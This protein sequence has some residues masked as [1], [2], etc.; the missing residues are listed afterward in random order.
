VWTAIDEGPQAVY[1]AGYS[2][3]ESAIY[4]LTLSTAGSFPVLLA[5][6]TAIQMAEGEKVLG[7]QSA[8]GTVI[9]VATSRGF[10]LGIFGAS[11]SIGLGPLIIVGTTYGALTTRDR[12]IYVGYQDSAGVAGMARVDCGMPLSHQ[13][14]TYSPEQI[15]AWCPDVRAE[16]ATL[17]GAYLGGAV[18]SACVLNDRIA[19]AVTGQGTFV[20]HPS[21]LCK[22]GTLLSSR[23]RMNTLELKLPRFIRLRSEVSF[24]TIAAQ[25]GIETDVAGPTLATLQPAMRQDS[26]DVLLTSPPA[27]WVTLTFTLTRQSDA[28]KDEGPVFTGFQLKVLPVVNKQR[29][30]RVPVLMFNFEESRT[31]QVLGQNP[32]G[33]VMTRLLALEAHENAG[34]VVLFQVLMRDAAEQY[35]VLV[36]I[37]DIEFEQPEGPMER[38]GWGGQGVI[39]LRTVQ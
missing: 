23:E 8:M 35:S 17:T 14:Y 21:A 9:G 5:G 39:T 1:V 38:S 6:T 37:D 29:N 16:D 33:P 10:R 2:Q 15:Y 20:E 12:Y 36:T 11:G 28:R 19:F 26:G 31:G 27:S 30:I 18:S 24:G 4:S 3:Y 25:I 32:A 34:D 7:L 22:T 13:L